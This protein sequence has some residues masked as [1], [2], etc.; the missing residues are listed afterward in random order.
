MTEIELIRQWNGIRWHLIASQLAPTFLLA[1]TIGLLGSGLGAAP[2]S[3]R[4]AA[5]GILLAS[6]ILGA[7]V[8]ISTAGEAIA[9]A[10]DLRNVGTATALGARIVSLSP[11]AN[12]VRYVSPAI[13]VVVFIA[14]IVALFG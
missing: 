9:V 8:Q 7:L 12:V 3:V 6:G 2:L 10:A 14:L 4:I 11:W 1:V 13:F 5:A